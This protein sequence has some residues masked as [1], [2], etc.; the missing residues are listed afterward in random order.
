VTRS[1]TKRDKGR[2]VVF[3]E[4]TYLTA[5]LAKRSSDP[6]LRFGMSLLT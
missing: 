4:Y 2:L 5:S 1:F 3:M 6:L